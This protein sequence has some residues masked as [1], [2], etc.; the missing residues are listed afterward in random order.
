MKFDK[1]LVIMITDKNGSRYINVSMVFRH[2]IMYVILTLITLTIF[3]YV[4]ITVINSE[5]R[6]IRH[7][8]SFISM[9]YVRMQNQNAD[10]NNEIEQKKEETILV[11]EKIEDLEDRLGIP[12]DSQL[13]NMDNIEGTDF[14]LVNRIDTAQITALQKVFL[15]KLIPNGVPLEHY[16]RISAPFGMRMHPILHILRFHAGIDLATKVGTPVY[17]SADGVVDYANNGYNGGYGKLVKISHSFGF[18]TYYAHL[19]KVLVQAG[20]FVKKGQTI[21]YSGTTGAST[22]PHLHYEIRFL[23]KPINPIGFIRWDLGNFDDIFTKERNIAWQSLLVIIN[24][25][26]TKSQE[27][28]LS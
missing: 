9:E 4:S 24:R 20:E 2:I 23:G 27:P 13:E 22:G 21:A 11:G 16:S 17:A 26:M 8:N 7:K 10:L 28:P 12:K 14:S 6:E 25:L 19:S 18:R 3:A 15:L 1:R 5:I